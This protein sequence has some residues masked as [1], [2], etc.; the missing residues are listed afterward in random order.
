MLGVA[1]LRAHGI[2]IARLRLARLALGPLSG[3]K[4]I[5]FFPS[6]YHDIEHLQTLGGS[7]P[8]RSTGLG[9]TFLGR[10]MVVLRAERGRGIL[11]VASEKRET[12]K[13][14]QNQPRSA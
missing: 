10:L 7:T 9:L 5:F 6:T 1:G 11:E 12:P 4:T 2:A 14:R 3:G 13:R 8:L